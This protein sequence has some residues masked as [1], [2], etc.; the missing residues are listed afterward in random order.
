LPIF[1]IVTVIYN[2]KA[3]LE[4][5]IQS[6]VNQNFDSFEYLVIDGGSI[7]GSLEVVNKYKNSIDFIISEPDNG[8]YDAMNKGLNLSNGCWILFLNAG[9]VFIDNNVLSSVYP[10]MLD[11]KSNY[12]CIANVMYNNEI[13]YRKPE[14]K[15]DDFKTRLPIHQSFFLSSVYKN[16]SFDLRYRISADS[17]QLINLSKFSNCIFIPLVGVNFYL[18]GISSWYSNY[19]QYSLHL[20]EHLLLVKFLNRGVFVQAYIIFVFSLK[21]LSTFV[22]SKKMYFRIIGFVSRIRK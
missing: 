3:E 17:F 15:I 16:Y 13:L 4:K 19:S 5:T 22:L 8:I 1:S 10:Y 12:Y 2:A 9:D 18:G 21:F 7:D 11:R 6:V 14:Q 20:K